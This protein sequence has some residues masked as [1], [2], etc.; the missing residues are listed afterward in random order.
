MGG[1]RYAI[2]IKI[3]CKHIPGIGLFRLVLLLYMPYIVMGSENTSSASP[4][5]PLCNSH[6][7]DHINLDTNGQWNPSWFNCQ[8]TSRYATYIVWSPLYCTTMPTPCYLTSLICLAVKNPL[9]YEPICPCEPIYKTDE[10]KRLIIRS[11]AS[12]N[13]EYVSILV[14]EEGDWELNFYLLSYFSLPHWAS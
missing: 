12:A 7:I 1:L 2:A 5:A 13:S 11:T 3:T 14:R 9:K 4:R 6:W 10:M 8:T